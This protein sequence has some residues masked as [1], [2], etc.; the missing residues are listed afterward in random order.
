MIGTVPPIS[1]ADC[2]WIAFINRANN[3]VVFISPDEGKKAYYY[4]RNINYNGSVGPRC[5][6]FSAGII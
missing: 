2:T 3:K 6:M 4:A 5:A 1:V